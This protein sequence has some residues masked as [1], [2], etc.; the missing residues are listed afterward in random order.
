MTARRATRAPSLEEEVL[1][2][3]K[4]FRAAVLRDPMRSTIKFLHT[5]NVSFGAIAALM[6]LRERG[7]QSI[8]HL[9]R[10]IGLS[11]AATSQLVGRL[12][13]DGLVVRSEHAEDRRSKHVKLA[14]K[15]EA[16]LGR[17]DGS[18]FASAAQMLGRVPRPALRRL[19]SALEEVRQALATRARR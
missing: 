8:S 2:A 9:S 5:N 19:Q 3:F 18:Y 6:T 4:D 10:E 13:N 15:G 14:A 11:L 17:I 16:L 7:D 12:V 1:R